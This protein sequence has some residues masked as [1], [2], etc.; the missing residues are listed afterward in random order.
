[1]TFTIL[2]VCQGNICRSP[3]MQ[4]QLTKHLE[5]FEGPAKLPIS[6][7][8]RGL[9]AAY[10]AE[11]CDRTLKGLLDKDELAGFRRA[12]RVRPATPGEVGRAQLVLAAGLEERAAVVRL[13]V[14]ARQ[15]TFTMIEAA[16]L[17]ERVFDEHEVP[18]HLRGEDRLAWFV[19]QMD[20]SRGALTLFPRQQRRSLLKPWTTAAFTE[21]DIPDPHASTAVA[22]ALVRRRITEAT[23]SFG[24]SLLRVVEPVGSTSSA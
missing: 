13:N 2:T 5:R 24:A 4:A 22:H 19:D 17:A 9:A 6:I 14:A 15:R 20:A 8:S 10:D 7:G 11:L 16:R 23:Q 18:A 1:M 21:L 3:S 12:H